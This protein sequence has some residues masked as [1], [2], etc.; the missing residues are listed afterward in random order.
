MVCLSNVKK[1]HVVLDDKKRN[2]RE[3]SSWN[4]PA[5]LEKCA[6]DLSY[7]CYARNR[8]D[9]VVKTRVWGGRILRCRCCT[10]RLSSNNEGG[11]DKNKN[12]QDTQQKHLRTLERQDS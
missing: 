5:C 6:V 4:T 7:V 12:Q 2:G 11:G 9:R 10:D 3:P 8:Y 1:Y